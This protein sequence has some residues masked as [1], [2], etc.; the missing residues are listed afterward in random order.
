MREPPGASLRALRL[1]RRL[2]GPRSPRRH[3]WRVLGR[4]GKRKRV[5]EFYDLP[6]SF[7]IDDLNRGNDVAH[8]VVDEELARR[9]RS[10][11]IEARLLGQV[12]GAHKRELLQAC[13]ALLLPS[14]VL[15]S[16]RSEG[17][18]TVVLEAM[19]HG[20][21]VIASDV[22]GIAELVDSPCTGLLVPPDASGALERAV[23]SLAGD[24]VL[25]SRLAER[26]AAVAQAHYW[27]A[28]AP[29]LERLLTSA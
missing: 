24:P 27:S 15:P 10:V 14:R 25:R 3:P 17:A 12:G 18:P 11:R 13:D 22:G 7:V 9:A 21:P 19:A 2:E 4:C 8:G 1:A 26:A 29:K 28:L 16:G 20:L 23:D 6:V 5:L